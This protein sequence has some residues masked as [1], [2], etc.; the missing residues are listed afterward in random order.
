MTSALTGGKRVKPNLELAVGAGRGGGLD[1]MLT[2]VP[3][4]FTERLRRFLLHNL[5]ALASDR[6]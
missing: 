3:Y 1:Q 6:D 4:I 5:P 2:T